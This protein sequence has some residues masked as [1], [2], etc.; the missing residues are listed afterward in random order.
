MVVAADSDEDRKREVEHFSVMPN[1]TGWR[2]SGGKMGWRA[3]GL[4]GSTSAQRRDLSARGPNLTIMTAIVSAGHS[5]TVLPHDPKR[6]AIV[7]GFAAVARLY[8]R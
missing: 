4:T 5:D 1:A 3:S 2:S 6:I 8:G 7:R